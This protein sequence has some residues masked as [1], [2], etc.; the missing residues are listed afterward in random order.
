MCERLA[1]VPFKAPVH[2][3]PG[4]SADDHRSRLRKAND[5]AKSAAP[6]AIVQTPY[7]TSR[8]LHASQGRILVTAFGLVTG[9]G[10]K[11]SPTMNTPR[12]VYLSALFIS[13]RSG[14]VSPVRRQ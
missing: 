10:M 1:A 2:F 8:P 13:F 5:N 6:T 14:G 9:M 12:P 11:P 7:F 3:R 4:A